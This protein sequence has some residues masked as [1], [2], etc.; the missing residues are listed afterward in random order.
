VLAATPI[1]LVTPKE[2]VSITRKTYATARARTM[3]RY[4]IS[5]FFACLSF[6]SLLWCRLQPVSEVSDW[7][8]GWSA[9][10]GFLCLAHALHGWRYSEEK[11]V[12]FI[13]QVIEQHGS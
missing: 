13:V 11:T 5:A 12:A 3:T 4:S 6:G 1:I 10:N 9:I 8:T 2:N 7:L